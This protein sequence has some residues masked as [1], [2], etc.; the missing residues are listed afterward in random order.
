MAQKK[1][2]KIYCV[3]LLVAESLIQDKIIDVSQLPRWHIFSVKPNAILTRHA[4]AWTFARSLFARHGGSKKNS[5]HEWCV[6]AEFQI[7]GPRCLNVARLKLPSRTSKS[8]F[9]LNLKPESVVTTKK[10]S[11][12]SYI[13]VRNKPFTHKGKFVNSGVGLYAVPGNFLFHTEHIWSD[14][15]A[16][17]GEH[18][19][20]AM[21]LMAAKHVPEL[22]ATEVVQLVQPRLSMQLLMPFCK[23]INTFSQATVDAVVLWVDADD[24]AWRKSYNEYATIRKPNAARYG[25]GSQGLRMCL[26]SLH[27]NVPFLRHIY[28]VTADQTPSWFCEGH[29]A[30]IISHRDL[31]L[32]TELLP[33]FNSSAIESVVH[34]IPNL[35]PFF[36]YSNDDM[37]VLRQTS[38]DDW[39]FSDGAAKSFLHH[40]KKTLLQSLTGENTRPF[41]IQMFTANAC[42][43]SRT[44]D[45]PEILLP[46]PAHQMSM[47]HI[48]AYVA[49]ESCIPAVLAHTR[50]SRFRTASVFSPNVNQYV[51]AE[52]MCRM[53][54]AR[55]DEAFLLKDNMYLDLGKKKLDQREKRWLR[56]GFAYCPMLFCANDH[57]VYKDRSFRLLHQ[58][59]PNVLP[60]EAPWEKKLMQ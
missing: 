12:A 57:E 29:G 3:V 51:A 6:F 34:R 7:L 60:L 21:C 15:S 11:T 27:H 5:I 49:I 28:V 32:S 35:S 41:D 38:R 40:E 53:G 58:I 2:N 55:R 19:P 36:L 39:F 4:D 48:D 43:A 54:L 33:T 46:R 47:H 8:V 13:L 56:H 14:Y 37:F 17:G 26:R 30:T 50:N 59:L 44:K 52:V 9:W 20:L 16:R 25:P 22:G 42:L 45:A 23:G 18:V 24:E 1:T 10:E 31:F